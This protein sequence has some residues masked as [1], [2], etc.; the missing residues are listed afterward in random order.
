MHPRQQPS[1]EKHYP[2]FREFDFYPNCF[3][4]KE[5]DEMI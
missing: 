5:I 2:E 3:P 1:G 4:Y